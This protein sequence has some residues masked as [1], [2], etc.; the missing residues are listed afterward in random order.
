MFVYQLSE[1]LGMRKTSAHG[2]RMQK[3]PQTREEIFFI[4]MDFQSY[5]VPKSNLHPCAE[6]SVMVSLTM[7]LSITTSQLFLDNT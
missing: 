7:K 4:F 3:N 5:V 6:I 2:I 1:G